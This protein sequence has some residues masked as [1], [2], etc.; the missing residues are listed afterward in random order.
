MSLPSESWFL[1]KF[2]V[3]IHLLRGEMLIYVKTCELFSHQETRVDPN[4]SEGCAPTRAA[5]SGHLVVGGLVV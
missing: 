5:R 2:K 1:S 4:Q 3:L